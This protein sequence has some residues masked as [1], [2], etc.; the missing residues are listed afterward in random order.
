MILHFVSTF[1]L[2]PTILDIVVS[3][4]ADTNVLRKANTL[5]AHPPA[6]AEDVMLSVLRLAPALGLVWSLLVP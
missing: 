3:V 6:T 2:K 1:A 4:T 5:L